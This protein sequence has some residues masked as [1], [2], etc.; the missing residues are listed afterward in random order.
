MD[1]KGF[2]QG[3]LQESKRVVP[4]KMLQQGR[5]KGAG[6]DGSRTW[7]TIIATISAAGIYL[8]PCVIFKGAGNLQTTWL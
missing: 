1:E 7:I 8:P 6:Q 3:K 4:V 2:L 5:I